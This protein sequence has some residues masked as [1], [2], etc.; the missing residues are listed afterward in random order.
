MEN[1]LLHVGGA[2]PLAMAVLAGEQAAAE[3][4]PAHHAGAE[5]VGHREQLT[6]GRA[7]DQAV[8]GLPGGDGRPAA[9]IRC[10]GGGDDP[11]GREIG[12]ARIHDLPGADEVVEAARDLVDGG[13][14]VVHVDEIKVDAVGREAFQA[15]LDRLDHGLAGV[16]EPG[17]GRVRRG[18]EGVLRGDDEVV[19]VPCDDLA[20]QRLGLAELVALGGVDEVPPASM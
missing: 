16:A 19:A 12:E 7:L 4:R 6:L 15:A 14:A 5:G 2:A 10:P 1:A 8:L 13:H 9:Q 3:R 20:D 18:A 17:Q 11:P